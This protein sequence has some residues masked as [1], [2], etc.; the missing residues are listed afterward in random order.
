MPVSRPYNW[1]QSVTASDRTIR[2][3]RGDIRLTDTRSGSIPLVF[4]HGSGSSRK[5]F[6]RQLNSALAD[7][8]TS[9][10][11]DL[12]ATANLS[13]QAT[14]PMPIRS[15]ALPTPSARCS[16]I[17]DRPAP[18]WLGWSLGGHIAIEL[19]A[20]NRLVAGLMS[21]AL[22][23]PPGL[24]GMMRGSHPSFDILLRFEG[25]PI[26]RAMPS[27]REALLRHALDPPPTDP[28]CRRRGRGRPFRKA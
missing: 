22:P 3:R 10:H 12:P 15:K 18:Q 2:T 23:V 24:I 1:R 4:L 13:T 20:R 7:D 6:E 17:G 21:G 28:P 25:K 9:S 8:R 26:R 19:L 16:I 14:R 11:S 5:V 27:A